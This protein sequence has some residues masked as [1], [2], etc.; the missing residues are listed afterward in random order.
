MVDAMGLARDN[1]VAGL[2]RFFFGQEEDIVADQDEYARW[3]TRLATAPEPFTLSVLVL[4]GF[5]RIATNPRLF[6]PPSTL[7]YFFAF[8]L[9]LVERPRACIVGPGPDH[10]GIFE[11]LC[12][13]A[14]AT[15]KLVAAAHVL[16]HHLLD[17]RKGQH[18]EGHAR[19]LA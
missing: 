15:G 11:R 19:S 12:R 18:P 14:G 3:L 2:S 9:S 7:K 16:R 8:V 17:R 10:L 5:V 6:D 1:A 13:D 4:C